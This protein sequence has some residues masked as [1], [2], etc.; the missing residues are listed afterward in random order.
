MTGPY[1]PADRRKPPMP[2]VHPVS[3]PVRG[4]KI[5]RVLGAVFLAV[6]VTS[7]IIKTETRVNDLQLQGFEALASGARREGYF[8]LFLGFVGI[9]IFGGIMLVKKQSQNNTPPRQ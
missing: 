8:P 3:K 7:Q 5:P 9:L 6:I 2:P 1:D 4:T